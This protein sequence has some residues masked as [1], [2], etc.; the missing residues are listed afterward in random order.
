MSAIL[1]IK[2]RHGGVRLETVASDE[3]IVQRRCQ[4]VYRCESCGFSSSEYREASRHL[5]ETHRN[6]R[7][8]S[9]DY[10]VIQD[11]GTAELV[12]NIDG[13]R[14]IES[15]EWEGPGLYRLIS[16]PDARGYSHHRLISTQS[17]IAMLNADIAR[18]QDQIAECIKIQNELEH[19]TFQRRTLQVVGSP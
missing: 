19:E 12:E 13:K 11:A 4:Q 14:L 8:I 5:I 6:V 18:V 9:P 15:I 17:Y 3:I 2:T 1:T 10:V 7:I 16:F